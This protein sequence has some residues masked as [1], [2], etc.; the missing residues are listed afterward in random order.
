MTA[1]D[2]DRMARRLLAIGAGLGIALAAVGIVG[3][4]EPPPAVPPGAVAVVNGHPVSR[5]IFARLVAAVAEERKRVTLDAETRSRLLERMLDEELLLQRGVELDL[6]RFEPTARRAIVAALIA[7]V[8][9]DAEAVEPDPEQLRDFYAEN[10]E[11]FTRSGRISLDAAF[12]STEVR[13]DAEARRMAEEIARRLRIGDRFDEVHAALADSPV[14]RLPSGPLSI[15]TVR[16]Y[17]GPTV[18]QV[19][20]RLAVGEVS[21]PTRASPGYFVLRLRDRDPGEVGKFDEILGRVR[22]EYL[23]RR[24]EEGLRDYLAGLREAAEIQILDA[25]RAPE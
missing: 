1:T 21:D 12:V 8:A 11:L 14:A 22:S 3:S 19:A 2:P 23:R 25:D 10:Q 4:G 18:A 13:P 5:E 15:E 24:G 7:S 17:L 9:A 6:H 16:Q 20:S